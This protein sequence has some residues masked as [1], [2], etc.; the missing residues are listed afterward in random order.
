MASEDHSQGDGRGSMGTTHTG[1]GGAVGE[2]ASAS[3]TDVRNRVRRHIMDRIQSGRWP[4]GHRLPTEKELAGQ[5]DTSRS[6]INQ[7]IALLEREGLV[8]RYRRRGTFVAG[9]PSTAIEQTVSQL[10]PR[11]GAVHV[12]APPPSDHA[13]M[14]WNA[15][16]LS[17]LESELNNAG[18]Q[19]AH[20]SLPDEP[21]L[22]A[23]RAMVREL[24]REGS[25]GLVILS[26]LSRREKSVA[27]EERALLPY[28]RALLNYPGR[29]CWLN[30]K[31]MPLTSWPYDAVSLSPLNE[32]IAAGRYLKQ[33]GVTDVIALGMRPHRWSRMRVA[34]VKMAMEDDEAGE[35]PV[36]PSTFWRKPT[37]DLAD[38][39][40]PLLDEV[41]KRRARPTLIVP[42]DAHAAALLDLAKQRGL[43]CPQQFNLVAFNNDQRYREYNITT[44]AP[45]ASH[46][47]E[48]IGRLV[49]D[50]IRR[51]NNSAIHMTLKPV[52]VERA[53]F[54]VDEPR[55]DTSSTDPT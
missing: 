7:A 33:Q 32:G 6:N 23:F 50:Q 15:A 26:D 30:R 13:S 55:A 14:H 8:Q 51:P 40:A 21:D 9:V 10:A 5:F 12:A 43:R 54:T 36:R 20:R 24:T 29:V 35:P 16:T 48:A 52:I 47:G 44:V 31:G 49:H 53:T 45:P 19:V 25:R 37:E 38:A 3:K 39:V 28:A 18:L 2:G 27:E 34:G 17:E 1:G 4:V 46:L 41:P 22:D 11:E 42:N